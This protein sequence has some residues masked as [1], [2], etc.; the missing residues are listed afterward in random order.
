MMGSAPTT[1]TSNGCASWTNEARSSVEP[2]NLRVTSPSGRASRMNL[3]LERRRFLLRTGQLLGATVLGGLSLSGCADGR[4][5]T[6]ADRDLM[7]RQ[8]AN[9][10]AASGQGPFG[11]QRY[12]G[13][14]GL[15][16]LPWYEV[17]GTGVLRMV[18]DSVPE[19]IDFHCHLGMSMLFEPHLDLTAR[20]ER[21]QHLLDCDGEDPPCELDLDVYINANFSEAALHDLPRK[22]ITQGL[23]GNDVVRTHTVLAAANSELLCITKQ[24]ERVFVCP[25]AS[26]AP[27]EKR[28]E[29]KETEKRRATKVDYTAA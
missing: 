10:A 6:E 22:T 14:R 11:P 15:A 26:Q 8:R 18:D 24:D 17:D 3:R 16:E 23:W 1:S 12:R 21:V 27:R 19:A 4:P 29:K 7:A 25:D 20:T 2:R 28:E 5:Y 13:Y 9:E